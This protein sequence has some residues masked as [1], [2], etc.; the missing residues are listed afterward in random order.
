MNIHRSVIKLEPNFTFLVRT[1][2]GLVEKRIIDRGEANNLDQV[3]LD[4][5]K[6][7]GIYYDEAMS[8]RNG[9]D[10]KYFTL[11]NFEGV[12]L[13]TLAEEAFLEIKVELLRLE[14]I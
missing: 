10:S 6:M 9:I 3:A 14:R 7:M 12:G 5:L 4:N 8:L 11:E 1:K 2:P 13:E